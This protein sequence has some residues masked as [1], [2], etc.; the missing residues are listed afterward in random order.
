MPTTVREANEVAKRPHTSGL[1][2]ALIIVY[3]ILSLAATMRAVYQIIAKFDEA[4]LAY[5]LSLMSGIV[6]IVATIALLRRTGVWRTVGI[7]ALIFE[8]AGVLVVGTLSLTMPEWFAHPSVWSWYGAGYGW[9]PLVLPIV[10]LIWLLRVDS[11]G[12]RSARSVT[13]TDPA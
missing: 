9:V 12:A 7:A 3:V 10:G 5:S 4:P 11:K 13:E 1:G 2:Y 6:Y 8:L